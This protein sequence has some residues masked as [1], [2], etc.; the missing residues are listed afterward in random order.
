MDYE[1][2]LLSRIREEYLV[3]RDTVESVVVGIRSTARVITSAAMV[4]IAVFL[5]FM[6]NESVTVKMIG[7]GLAVAV[8]VDATVVRIVLVPSTMVLLGHANWWLPR[9]LDRILPHLEIEGES[10]LP[11]VP[12]AAEA[13]EPVPRAVG[14]PEPTPSA[15]YQPDPPPERRLGRR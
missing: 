7:F 6:L 5:A 4:M 3:D 11:P 2:F 15:E 13:A 8:L 9:W 12:R 1:V 14:T 10:G